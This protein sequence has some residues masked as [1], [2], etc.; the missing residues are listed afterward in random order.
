MKIHFRA[1]K[2]VIA[3]PLHRFGYLLAGMPPAAGR[4]VVGGIGAVARAAYFLPNSHLSRTLGNFCQVA[5]RTDPWPV[6][7]R[8]IDNIEQAALHFTR[9]YR[10]GRSELLAQ[11]AIDSGL[12]AE[13][14]RLGGNQQG[15]IIL[16][17]HCV[18]AVLSSARLST[19][20]PTVL[21]VREP[22]DPGRCRLLLEYLQ[23][24]GPEFIFARNA[25]PAMV[26]RNIVRALKEGKV[27]VGTTD[28]VKADADTVQTRA[29]EQRIH[30]AAWPARLS[31]RL[32]VPIIPGYIHMEGDQI[33]LLADEGY[34]DPDIQRST[35]RWVHSFEKRFRQ[36][37]SDWAFMLDKNWARVLAAAASPKEAPVPE[38]QYRD[39]FTSG[40]RSS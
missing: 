40:Q 25:P 19:V 10:Y 8:M 32:E 14:R 39:P 21:L 29:F 36:Y 6:F 35:Q 18:G 22:K 20:S 38:T 7:S 31:A 5:G 12:E 15:A 11:T 3:R 1:V 33:T 27:V 9:L 37:P 17:P 13:L 34:V 24:L 28:L 2:N 16:V 30:S 26:I 23:K 4:G